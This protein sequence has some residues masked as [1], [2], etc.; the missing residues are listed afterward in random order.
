MKQLKKLVFKKV[1]R[2]SLAKD[3][4]HTFMWKPFGET[5]RSVVVFSQSQFISVYFIVGEPAS[6]I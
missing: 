3:W 1:R 5:N 2:C 4:S 6:E